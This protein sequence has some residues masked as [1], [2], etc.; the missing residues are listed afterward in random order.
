MR[1]ERSSA[2]KRKLEEKY[3]KQPVPEKGR[4]LKGLS[5]LWRSFAGTPEKGPDQT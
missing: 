1:K 4:V 5:E 3:K 2:L